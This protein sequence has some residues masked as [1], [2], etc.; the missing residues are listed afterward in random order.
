MAQEHPSGNGEGDL[1]QAIAKARLADYSRIL[2]LT[3]RAIE[4]EGAEAGALV[5]NAEIEKLAAGRVKN[6]LAS[7]IVEKAL[8]IVRTQRK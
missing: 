8:E 1:G 7:V 4:A 2:N 6:I 5:L 3:V